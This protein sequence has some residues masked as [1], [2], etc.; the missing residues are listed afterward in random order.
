VYS[1]ATYGADSELFL[2]FS[3]GVANVKASTLTVYPLSPARSRFATP[4]R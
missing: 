1:A 3:E 2:N 4:P